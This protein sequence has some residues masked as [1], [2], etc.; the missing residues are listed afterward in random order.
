MEPLRRTRHLARLLLACFALSLG[1]AMA[2]PLVRVQGLER[3]C[4]ASGEVRWV[5]AGGNGAAAQGPHGQGLECALCLPP[6]LPGAQAA[7]LPQPQGQPFMAQ[8][9]RVR[10]GHVPALSRAAFPPR[11]PPAPAP[12][13]CNLSECGGAICAPPRCAHGPG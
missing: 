11:A 6:M 5:A 4:S 13:P 1:V 9:L 10:I 3:L 2:A 7:T 8:A 12:S